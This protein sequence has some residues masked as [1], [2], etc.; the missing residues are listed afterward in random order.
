VRGRLFNGAHLEKPDAGDH[1]GSLPGGFDS[2]Q[3]AADD[4]YNF[5]HSS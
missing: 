4:I 1:F 5:F 2:G 3:P